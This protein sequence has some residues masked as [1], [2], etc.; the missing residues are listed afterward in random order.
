M[1][2]GFLIPS[3]RFVHRRL[4]S[5]GW[6]NIVRLWKKAFIIGNTEELDSAFED[7]LREIAFS[8]IWDYSHHP[9]P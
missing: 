1:H 3:Y 7:F 2:A 4:V 9:L 8:G 5:Q 6:M